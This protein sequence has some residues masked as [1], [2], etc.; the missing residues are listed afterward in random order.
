MMNARKPALMTIEEIDFL[1]D[2]MERSKL[3]SGG[4]VTQ[5]M[6]DPDDVLSLARMARA[7][8][9]LHEWEFSATTMPSGTVRLRCEWGQFDA[10]T[11][12]EAI[13]AAIAE[14]TS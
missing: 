10:A 12:T 9:L 2:T 13:E 3:P 6:P 5:G 11:P 4:Y 14:A 8:A 1:L 7:I